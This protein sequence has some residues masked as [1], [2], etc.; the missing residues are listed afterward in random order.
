[1]RKKDSWPGSSP[2]WPFIRLTVFESLA[3]S[4]P[5]DVWRMSASDASSCFL[6]RWWMRRGSPTC[7]SDRVVMSFASGYVVSALTRSPPPNGY[8]T[9]VGRPAG[10]SA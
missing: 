5:D 9:V 3:T 6:S 10:F 8:T 4:R 1:M 7:S 2:R